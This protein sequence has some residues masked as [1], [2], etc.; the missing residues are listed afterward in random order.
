[1]GSLGYLRKRGKFW[2]GTVCEGAKRVERSLQTSNLH[3]AKKRLAEWISERQRGLYKDI[4][5][6]KFSELAEKWVENQ[7][8][9][10][11]KT[12]TVHS[13]EERLRVDLLP[14]FGNFVVNEIKPEHIEEFKVKRSKEVSPRTVNYSLWVLGNILDLA[15]R[16]G[17]V[18]TN[19]AKLVKGLKQ[20]KR[21]HQIPSLEQTHHLLKCASEADGQWYTF[22]LFAILS[23][24]RM[25]EI[26]AAKWANVNWDKFTYSVKESF[27]KIGGLERPKTQG[28]YRMIDLPPILIEQ[29]RKHKTWQNKWRLSQG[30]N[31]EEKGLIFAS[32][33]G[34]HV[35]VHNFRKRVLYPLLKRSGLPHIRFHDLRGLCATILLEA[36]APLKYVQDQLGHK[37]PIMTLGIYA[38]VTSEARQETQ[39][40]VQAYFLGA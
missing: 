27:T 17:H 23:G 13:Y 40:R 6:I 4:R 34:N 15:V 19:C 30:K 16:N 12:R 33:N 35:D 26:L 1:M 22:F 36:G 2:H 29:L 24:M 10:D 20:T 3:E 31:Y 38:R 25:G 8:T 9:P 37:S 39:K 28:S 32:E 7:K 5:K 14:F 11:K 21:E 18:Y